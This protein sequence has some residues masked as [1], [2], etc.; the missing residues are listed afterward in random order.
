[1]EKLKKISLGL[2]LMLCICFSNKSYAVVGCNATINAQKQE[3]TVEDEFTVTLSISNIQG[4]NGILVLGGVL[5]YDKNV[6]TLIG[7]NTGDMWSLS[8]NGTTGQFVADRD[9]FAKNNQKVIT[10]KF[11]AIKTGNTSIAVKNLL[12]TDAEE[13]K[14]ING[15]S[16]AI[17]IK[18][19][20]I[21][22]PEEKPEEKPGG[23]QGGS[24]G[25]NQGGNNN[26]GGNTNQGGNSNQGN[27]P[28]DNNSNNKPNENTNN[29]NNI[30]QE[31]NTNGTVSGIENRV[32]EQNT[33]NN[34][35]PNFVEIEEEPDYPEVKLYKHSNTTM[36]M[37]IVCGVGAVLVGIV[38]FVGK[39]MIEKAKK[40]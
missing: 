7:R 37:G 20:N 21:E 23:S 36:V 27:K 8:Y 1:M 31:T 9:G 19:K 38:L 26:Q 22:K 12:V 29:E 10:F 5:E 15:A 14:G 11:K 17:S 16:T 33:A 34:S 24:Q 3:I 2:I 13:E 4:E 30:N 28:S 18:A 25:G 40:Y 32:P 6:L 39:K 35:K